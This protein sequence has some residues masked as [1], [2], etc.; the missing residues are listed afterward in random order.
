[1]RRDEFLRLGAAILGS[2]LAPPLIHDWAADDSGAGRDLDEDVIRQVRAQTA[3]YRWL[4]RQ[5]GARTH[6]PDAA[7][8]ARRVIEAWQD[9]D[10]R[11]PL[12]PVLAELAADAC[13]LVAY[14]VFDQGRRG[15][16]TRWY[17]CAADLAAPSGNRDLYIFAVCGVAYMEAAQGHLIRSLDLHDQTARLRR[18]AAALS[19][20]HAYRGHALLAAQ[21][22]DGMLR[23]LD[24]AAVFAGHT[25]DEPPPSWLGVTGPVWV[26][27]QRA[28]LLTR[29]GS[30]DAVAALTALQRQ[31]PPLFARFHVTVATDLAR[32][33]S[34]N[35][36]YE[37]AA[38]SLTTA[39]AINGRVCSV[40]RARRMR[41]VRDGLAQAAPAPVLEQVDDA[42]RSAEQHVSPGP[43]T[44]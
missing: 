17:R 13:H 21:D 20:V 39:A 28:M 26:E 30:P 25:T 11:H 38:A 43:T 9:A 22:S 29:L 40:E 6:L 23:S 1:V 5:E 27:R 12:R 36:N 34:A 42:L 7:R 4:D 15:L 33:H 8:H 24:A 32:A 41:A 16:A 19:Y 18:S 3:G 37:G 31:T 35:G 2:V 14:Q 44:D 10:A